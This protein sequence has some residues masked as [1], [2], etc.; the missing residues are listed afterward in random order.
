MSLRY[1]SPLCVASPLSTLG[2]SGYR[3]GVSDLAP[4]FTCKQCSVRLLERDCAGHLSRHGLRVTADQVLSH[5]TKGNKA[6]VN[7]RPGDLTIPSYGT[8][9]GK[10]GKGRKRGPV[11]THDAET[12]ADTLEFDDN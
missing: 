10:K 11:V 5:F 6:E 1:I 12:D 9:H 2:K 7:D 4:M 3:A 8:L